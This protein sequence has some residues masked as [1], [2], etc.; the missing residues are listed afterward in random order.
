MYSLILPIPT[1]QIQ[2]TEK[3]LKPLIVCLKVGMSL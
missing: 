2:L 1:V 3:S